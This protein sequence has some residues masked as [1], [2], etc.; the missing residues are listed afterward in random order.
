MT[1]NM[2]DWIAG[3]LNAPHRLAMPIMTYPGLALVG[4]NVMDVISSGENQFACMKALGT[5]Y[6]A[7]AG[8]TL[9]DLSVE[10]EAFGCPI[11]YSHDEVPTVT[12]P[13]VHD[14]ESARAL[15]IPQ[16]ESGRTSVYLEAARR[17][18]AHFTDR[19]VFGGL[20][21]PY[22]LTVRL[23]DMTQVMI[24]LML[25]PEMIHV[26]LEKCTAFL[27]EYA[28][29]FKA[30]GANGV[31]IAEPAAGLLSKEF[32][33][34]FSSRYVK[35]IIDAVQDEDFFV[36]LHNC[37]KTVELVPSLLSTGA[38]GLHFGNAVEMTAV[39][40]QV[41][42]NIIAMG[43]IDPAGTFRAGT[44]EQVRAA[45]LDLLKKTAEYKNFVISSGCDIPPG[46]PLAN[47]DAFYEAL[48]EFNG[49]AESAEASC[50][51]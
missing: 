21:G 16:V 8:L 44:P 41:P 37:G 38:R 26:M 18:A 17:A 29:A 39:L 15:E 7:I 13:V 2:N 20:I 6:P 51:G 49:V 43:N 36:L 25:E 31:L 14:M 27:T 48:A 28:K 30:A 32:C 42:E 33:D 45:T 47:V 34:E 50:I 10:A 12:A 1:I 9:M 22:S 23:K 3:V 46:T 4:Q 11:K 35:R 19:P 40:P 5:T 24:D